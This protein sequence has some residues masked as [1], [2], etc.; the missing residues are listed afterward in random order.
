ASPRAPLPPLPQ[1][2][3]SGRQPDPGPA[4][5]VG[6]AAPPRTVSQLRKQLAADPRF[7][8]LGLLRRSGNVAV[9]TV[10]VR[11][12]AVG[13]QAVAAIRDLRHRILP[14]AL[15]GTGGSAAVGGQRAENIGRLAAG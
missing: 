9:L 14:A 12:D 2:R 15:A 8:G 7:G 13:K 5:I 3:A 6:V 10:P 11:G 1:R 4:R